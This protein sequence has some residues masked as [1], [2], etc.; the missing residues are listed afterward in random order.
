MRRRFVEICESCITGH[1]R[2]GM[3]EQRRRN[4]RGAF[5]VAAGHDAERLAVVGDDLPE[6]EDDGRQWLEDADRIEG[7]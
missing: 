6:L 4:A 5:A 2:R 3:A 1:D 7:E